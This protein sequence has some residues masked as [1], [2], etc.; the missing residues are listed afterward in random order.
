MR[1]SL[2]QFLLVLIKE[3]KCTLSRIRKRVSSSVKAGRQAGRQTGREAGREAGVL[4]QGTN[5]GFANIFFGVKNMFLKT[6]RLNKAYFP[7]RK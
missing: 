1:L 3:E 2:V 5:V 7:M 6:S 4:K